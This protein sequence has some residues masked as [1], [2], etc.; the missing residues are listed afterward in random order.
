ML[1][2]MLH[3]KTSP[4]TGKACLFSIAHPVSFTYDD[5]QVYECINIRHTLIP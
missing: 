1:C 4:P 2:Q 5:E 3:P